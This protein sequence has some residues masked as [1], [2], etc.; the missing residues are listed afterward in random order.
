LGVYTVYTVARVREG[1]AL[2]RRT[3]QINED[4]KSIS[5]KY[6]SLHDRLVD[7]GRSVARD[8]SVTRLDEKLVGRVVNLETCRRNKKE[9]ME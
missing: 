4:W 1:G 3:P 5:K 8:A 9:E 6:R 7:A 2:R